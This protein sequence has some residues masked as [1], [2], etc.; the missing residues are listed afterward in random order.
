LFEDQLQHGQ[1]PSQLFITCS[2]SRVIPSLITASGPGD[3]FVVRNIGNIVPPYDGLR[4]ADH[5]AVARSDAS[6][7]AAI[8]YA[9][10]ILGVPAITVCGHSDCGAMKAL[11]AEQSDSDAKK[12]PLLTKWLE[13]VDVDN[14]ADLC[15]ADEHASHDVAAQVNVINQLDNLSTYP[16]VQAA[17]ADRGLQLIGLYF[18]IASAE[19]RF[20]DKTRDRFVCPDTDSPPEHAG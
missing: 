3:L 10:D 5:D 19:V 18:D 12:R 15:D 11:L 9:V 1:N 8:E 17:I 16:S 20:F 14:I 7:G 4:S 6:V 2:D 13:H